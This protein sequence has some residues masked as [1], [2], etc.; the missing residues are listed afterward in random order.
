MRRHPDLWPGVRRTLERRVRAWRAT[1][2]PAQEIV[3]RQLHELGRMGLSDFTDMADLRIQVAGSPLN[4]LLYH[5]RLAYSG[6]Q[7]TH[8]VLVA[9][10]SSPWRKACIMPCGRSVAS[11]R[12]TART[13]CRRRF[14]IWGKRR[15]RTCPGAMMPCQHYGMTP[16]R[17]N[18]GLAAWLAA[19]PGLL[20]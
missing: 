3:F 17:N 2:G 1:H 16:S 20:P 11:R 15:K 8:V 9:R 4:H 10:A 13:V 18:R 5:F 14:V 6:F 7:H 19:L 12:N